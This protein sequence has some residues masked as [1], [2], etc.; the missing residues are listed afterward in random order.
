MLTLITVNEDYQRNNNKCDS[1]EQVV[2]LDR[3]TVAVLL[4][5]GASSRQCSRSGI[6]WK[7]FKSLMVLATG[8]IFN[9]LSF[10]V[11]GPLTGY[12]I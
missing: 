11:C 5:L 7:I 6:S 4:S 9:H 1:G 2:Y 3:L 8:I 10:L 12:A